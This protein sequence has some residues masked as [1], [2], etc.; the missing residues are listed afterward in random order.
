M[1]K[2]RGTWPPPPW[3][4]GGPGSHEVLVLS[5]GEAGD[6]RTQSRTQ[7][8]SP[9]ATATLSSHSIPR[10]E[11][12]PASV[13]SRPKSESGNWAPGGSGLGKTRTRT[14]GQ[15]KS[16]LG[17]LCIWS[18]SASARGLPLPSPGRLFPTELAVGPGGHMG[19]GWGMLIRASHAARCYLLR[20]WNAPHT[21]AVPPAKAGPRAP[22]ALPPLLKY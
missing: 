15:L 1:C 18:V 3:G 22:N 21:T 7:P 4:P 17:N 16:L 8:C 10:G 14:L 6:G 19:W 11:G 5:T 20:S 2:P 9:P 13:T 12:R